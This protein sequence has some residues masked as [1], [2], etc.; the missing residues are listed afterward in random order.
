MFTRFPAPVRLHFNLYSSTGGTSSQWP[1]YLSGTAATNKFARWWIGWLGKRVRIAITH[2]AR[3]PARA[4]FVCVPK[5][6]FLGPAGAESCVRSVS[7]NLRSS[8]RRVAPPVALR[9]ERSGAKGWPAPAPPPPP[10]SPT[11]ARRTHHHG[12]ASVS[13]IC[14]HALRAFA[15][16]LSRSTRST[17]SACPAH[18][19]RIRRCS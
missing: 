16:R 8:Q 4:V 15:C 5:A 11:T 13:P 3:A 6:C 17:I 2:T 19:A 12:P 18:A 1:R 9:L 7:A 10:H 14:L